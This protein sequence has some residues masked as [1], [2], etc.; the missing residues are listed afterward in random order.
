MYRRHIPAHSFYDGAKAAMFNK[1][2]FLSAV[3]PQEG[4]YCVVGLKKD[5]KPKQKFVGSIEEIG[6][7]SDSL[8]SNGSLLILIAVLVSHMQTKPK[9]LL[10]LKSF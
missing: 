3:L 4:S 10:R 7:L 5:E 2:S 8:V 6:A 9:A 1:D